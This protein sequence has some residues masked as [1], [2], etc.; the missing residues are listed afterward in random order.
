MSE[1]SGNNGNILR[2]P[3]D[4][5]VQKVEAQLQSCLLTKFI[6]TKVFSVISKKTSRVGLFTIYTRVWR[7]R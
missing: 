5:P 7:L 1:K 3:Y 6:T 2:N 4:N